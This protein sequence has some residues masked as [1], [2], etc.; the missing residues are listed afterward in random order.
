MELADL[1]NSSSKK[2]HLAMESAGRNDP[3][4]LILPAPRGIHLDKR[5]IYPK[6]KWTNK[7]VVGSSPKCVRPFGPF[8]GIGPTIPVGDIDPAM[9]D[10]QKHSIGFGGSTKCGHIFAA[11]HAIPICMRPS[12]LAQ[13][14]ILI[15]FK[16][17]SNSPVILNWGG[18]MA[19][20]KYLS[21]S[22]E[23]GQ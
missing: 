2:D 23:Q 4:L 1:K 14:S 6:L 5:L 22:L 3:S 19:M 8:E 17:P 7:F 10:A 15:P 13:Y 18:Y 11:I 9:K 16:I 21:S 12:I 20:K